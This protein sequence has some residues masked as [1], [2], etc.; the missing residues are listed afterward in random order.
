MNFIRSAYHYL[1]GT[2][3]AYALV[4]ALVIKAIVSDVSFATVFLTVPVL[5]FEAYK[6][7][8]ASKKPNPIELDEELR[9]EIDNIKS[10][11]NAQTME[12]NVKP[13]VGR[14]F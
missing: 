7:F 5:V 14:Y 12:K 8:M 1:C 3:F 9:K 11:L 4:L 6:A 13:A 10:K 2:N